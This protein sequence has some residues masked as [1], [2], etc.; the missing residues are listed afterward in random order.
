MQQNIDITLTLNKNDYPVLFQLKK[1]ELDK[2]ATK[3][4]NTGYSLLYPNKINE[5]SIEYKELIEKIESLRNDFNNPELYDKI[6]TLELSLEKLIGLSNSSSKKGELAE[7]VIENIFT[8]RY[9]DIEYVNTSGISHS[10]DAW[11]YLPNNKIVM[12]ESKNYTSVVNK[13]EIIKMQN[14]MITHHIRWG[15]FL[16]FNSNIQGMK[17]FDFYVFNHNNETYHVVMV[18]NLASDITRLDLAIGIIR[19]L[20]NFYSDLN[21][22][23]WIINNIKSELE[24][25]NEILEQNYL[26]RDNFIT[27]EKD[28]IKNVNNFYSK[29]RDYQINMNN[30]I[31]DIINKIN[32]TMDNSVVTISNDYTPFINWIEAKDKKLSVIATKIIDVFKKKELNVIIDNNCILKYS[33]I[34]VATVK[35]ILKKISI[36]FSNYDIILNFILN[37][38]K[39]IS[40]NLVIF[41]NL[42]L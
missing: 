42:N 20:V 14:D 16:S 18:S 5:K 1:K 34:T 3:I 15:I 21:K 40:Q 32:S 25:L 24:H 22:F 41:E 13:D 26:L 38:D 36:E 29:L 2:I 39:E 9:G 12:I 8:T 23:P 28:I 17:E 33:D 4:F 37:K 30:K 10:G 7:N 35:V 11:L 27:M 6:S 31:K 19:K